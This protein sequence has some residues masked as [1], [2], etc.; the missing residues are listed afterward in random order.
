MELEDLK[1]ITQL[2]A[3][4]SVLVLT[5][6]HSKLSLLNIF[7]DILSFFDMKPNMKSYSVTGALRILTLIWLQIFCR[8]FDSLAHPNI[9]HPI[10]E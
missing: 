1:H 5:A 8:L 3:G 6:G 9:I 2:V 10:Q 7:K 4:L